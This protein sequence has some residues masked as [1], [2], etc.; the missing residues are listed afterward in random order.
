MRRIVGSLLSIRWP[1][2]YSVGAAVRREHRT[3]GG[4]RLQGRQRKKSLAPEIGGAAVGFRG[5]GSLL[6]ND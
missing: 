3:A 2:W 4:E 6:L 5:A 1:E